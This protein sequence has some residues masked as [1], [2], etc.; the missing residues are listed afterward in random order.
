MR[1]ERTP[2]E[3]LLRSST[4]DPLAPIPVRAFPGPEALLDNKSAG[5]A[6]T[7]G[8]LTDTSHARLTS[9]LFDVPNSRQLNLEP[10]EILIREGDTADVV[11]VLLSGSLQVARTVDESTAVLAIIDE[12][13]TLVGEMVALG[14][15]T[16]T[17]TVSAQAASHVLALSAVEFQSALREDPALTEQLVAAAV[18]RAEEGE[19]AELLAHHFGIVDEDTL[20]STCAAVEWKRLKQGEVL[21]KEGEASDEVFFVVR[22]RLVATA[23]DQASDHPV[24]IG[25]AG[26]GDVVGEMGL[27]GRTPRTATMTALRDTVVAGMGEVAFLNLVER[28]PRMMIELSLRAVERAQNPRWHSAP[29]TVLAVVTLDNFSSD[30]LIEGM[31]SE[32]ENHG[33]ARRLSPEVIDATLGT[34]GAHAVERGDI[35]DVRVSR[36]VHEFELE[37]DHLI[38]EVGSMPGHWSRRALGM[39]DRVLVVAA[40]DLSEIAA[41]RAD[42]VLGDCPAGVERSLVL[43][44]GSLDAPPENSSYLASAFGASSVTHVRDG[45]DADAARLARLSV[46]RANTLVLSG[47]GGRGFA[48]IGAF[49]AIRDLGVPIDMVGGTSMGAVIGTVI[50]NAMDPDQIVDW[51]QQ[52]FPK[53]LDYTLPMVSLTKGGRI[54]RSA[55]ETFGTREIEDLWLSFFA[56]STD[57]TTSRAHIHDHGSVSLA[58]RATSAIPGVMP[59]VPHGDALLI[60]GGVLNN[61]P[62]DVARQRA[63]AGYLIA[64]DVA[65]PRGPGA[66][67]DYGLSVSGWQAIRSSLGRGRSPYPRIS[68]VLMRSMITASMRARDTHVANGLADCYLDL[69]MRGVSMLE[70]GDPGG[71][72]Q[73]GYEAALSHLEECFSSYP[74][75]GFT[76][77]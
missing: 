33:V 48:H 56:M 3:L 72:A 44:H 43:M 47:G 65:P 55:E 37:A 9:S 69:D 59:P 40:P 21:I 63:P 58:I 50:A 16:R 46:G 62:L 57:L 54:A 19:L 14:G 28:Q 15:G 45:D 11:Y 61:L 68:A 30:W 20:V 70:F 18:R 4:A 25:E 12:P 10:E 51:A 52:H 71:V 8:L 35:G 24:K 39:A 67:G 42:L 1:F 75:P 77:N 74:P 32:L 6:C 36:L 26:R 64:V 5:W 34:P 38:V 2:A 49:R 29:S 41:A 76:G 66:H 7:L 53:V 27:L 13:G 73:R 17:A 23:R 22:G 31:E 60:D